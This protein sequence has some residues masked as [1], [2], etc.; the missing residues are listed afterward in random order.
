MILFMTCCVFFSKIKRIKERGGIFG[1]LVGCKLDLWDGIIVVIPCNGTKNVI[2]YPCNEAKF[3]KI[4]PCN[5]TN[6]YICV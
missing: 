6:Y 5:E 2:I 4:Y 1:L 3:M